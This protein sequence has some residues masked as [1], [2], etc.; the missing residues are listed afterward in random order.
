[1]RAQNSFAPIFLMVKTLA[2]KAD[3]PSRLKRAVIFGGREEG[4]VAPEVGLEHTQLILLASYLRA[5]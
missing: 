3:T 1:V 5:C 4:E 2:K